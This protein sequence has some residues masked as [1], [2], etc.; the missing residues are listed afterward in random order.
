MTT[1]KNIAVA[2]II[3]LCTHLNTF[4][5]M[6]E[7]AQK[8][9]GIYQKTKLMLAAAAPTVIVLA[10]VGYACYKHSKDQNQQKETVR[11]LQSELTLQNKKEETIKKLQTELTLQKPLIAQLRVSLQTE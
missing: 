8:P 9:R 5:I 10:V 6:H 2:L 3:V 4:V 1:Q 7:E 11:Q